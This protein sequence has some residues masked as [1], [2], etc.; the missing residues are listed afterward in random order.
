MC[1]FI[2]QL[3]YFL[4]RCIPSF[5]ASIFSQWRR[6]KKKTSECF[7]FASTFHFMS[8]SPSRNW[9]DMK[10]KVS[11]EKILESE[12]QSTK[13]MCFP[14]SSLSRPILLFSF[15]ALPSESQCFFCDVMWVVPEI[16]S[17][18]RQQAR[19]SLKWFG[20]DF[21]CVEEMKNESWFFL[22]CV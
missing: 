20:L 8:V 15:P 19:F 2:K 1:I 14:F 4:W 12:E 18:G 3:V 11:R 22:Y 17:F 13:V 7:A 6:K 10:A 9:C 16:I 5:Y 21:F